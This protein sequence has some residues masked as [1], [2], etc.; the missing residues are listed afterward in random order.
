MAGAMP[1]VVEVERGAG[2]SSRRSQS[3]HDAVEDEASS[4]EAVLGF[5]IIKNCMTQPR[6]I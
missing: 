1:P 3:A 2:Q 4:G 6:P 5:K